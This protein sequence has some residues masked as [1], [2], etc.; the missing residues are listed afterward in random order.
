MFPRLA[1]NSWAQVILPPL[2]SQLA[3]TTGVHHH[4][5]ASAEVLTSTISLHKEHSDHF[6]RLA[7]YAVRNHKAV[8]RHT[9]LVIM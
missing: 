4:F 5:L 8:L 3:G 2:F 7:G 1:W 6:L 9:C